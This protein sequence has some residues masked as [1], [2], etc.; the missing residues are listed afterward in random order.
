MRWKYAKLLGNL[1]QTVEALCGRIAGGEAIVLTE[2]ARAEGAMVL[3]AAGVDCASP[4]EIAGLRTGKVETQPLADGE[5]AL[6]SS[7]QSL[8]R[9]TRS[10][11]ADHINGEIV[12]LGRTYGVLTPVNEALI[13]LANT[14]AREGLE[15]GG[16]TPARLL[17]LA[18]ATS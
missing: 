2:R 7:W 11:E 6:G 10:I 1:A 13:R 15:P 18:D 3:K 5:G 9:G 4:A 14:S 8:A 17:E 12:L 16:L